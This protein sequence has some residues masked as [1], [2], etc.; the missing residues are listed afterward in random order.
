MVKKGIT[1]AGISERRT[2]DLA[3]E[4]L[5]INGW[6]IAKPPKGQ[7]IRQNEYK[8]HPALES[9]FAGQSKSGAGDAYPDFLAVDEGLRPIMVVETKSEDKS[10]DA[11]IEEACHYGDAC[12]N[13]GNPVVAIGV[14]GQESSVLEI[15]VRK[16]VNGKWEPVTYQ[17]RPIE[18]VPRPG[19]VDLLLASTDAVDLEPSVPDRKVLAE[20]ADLLNRILREAKVRDEKRPAYIG[21]FMLALWQSKGQLRRSPQYVLGDVN[22][23]AE[24]AFAKGGKE[25]LAKSLRIDEANQKLASTAWQIISELILLNVVSASFAHDYLG[26]LYEEFFRYTG[27]NTIGQYFTPRHI[28][29][30]MADLC[31]TQPDDRVIDP[32]CGTGGFLIAAIER[33][34]RVGKVS[35]ERA[36]E[37]VRDNLIGYESEPVTA[38]L[39]VAN[40]I[41]RGDGKT[42]I[43]NADTLT[44]KDFPVGNCQVALM[45][46][47]FPHKKTDTPSERFVERALEA[48]D[49]RGRLA[50]I[51]PTS[52]LAK[53]NAASK[54]WRQ[55]ILKANTLRAVCSLP[56][57]LFEPYASTHTCIVLLEKGVAH[58]PAKTTV[59]ARIAHDGLRLRK[60][61]RVEKEDELNQLP[62]AVD[63]ILNHRASRGFVGLASVSAGGEWFPGGY[64]ESAV[65]SEA[66]VLDNVDQLLRR[67]TAFYGRYA[68]EIVVQRALV[69]SGELVPQP[70]RDLLSTA[71]KKNS[72][73]LQRNKG[74][75]GAHFDLYYGQKAL[76][77]REGIAP[78]SSLVISPTE[79]YN[80]CYGWLEFSELIS[81]SFVTVAQ[82]GSIGEAF[83]QVEP[84]A[85]NDDC[86]ILLPRD[87]GSS[88][89]AHLFVAAATIR[90]EKWRFNYGRKLTPSRIADFPF[91]C[92][93]ALLVE[94]ERMISSWTPIWTSMLQ[95]Y[96][97]AAADID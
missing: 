56:D 88:S 57:E 47:P 31:E 96:S 1:L 32:A 42:G 25:K 34:Q 64:I 46:P 37:I 58:D 43:Q 76:H 35:Y 61:V 12:R 24:E 27:G 21:A 23:A 80:G 93:D 70:Y 54:R 41:L 73:N 48:L 60:G 69:D 62:L 13:S 77:S 89:M 38:A 65:A 94:V 39:C 18:W 83:V 2:E 15:R 51:L 4:L 16:Y 92:S 84:C 33:A 40:M 71:R 14:A 74:T 19:D 86:L 6:Q 22:R 17:Q 52:L 49:K 95:N 91:P 68:R 63:A 36:V 53:N 66:D 87:T 9:I 67:L 29:Q 72:E 26:Q 11:A 78:G 81:P 10:I 30:F 28:T 59:F 45:N 97:G 8:G 75:I 20:K 7:V 44:A 90:S 79:A 5:R 50:V 85:V 3:Q 82:T 55:K